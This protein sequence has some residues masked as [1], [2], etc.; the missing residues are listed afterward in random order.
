MGNAGHQNVN[1]PITAQ[2]CPLRFM[3]PTVWNISGYK[4]TYIEAHPSSSLCKLFFFP[5]HFFFKAI[6][7]G[8]S[9]GETISKQLRE[10][11]LGAAMA[12]HQPLSSNL[13]ILVALVPYLAT[14]GLLSRACDIRWRG[15][16]NCLPREELHQTLSS[17]CDLE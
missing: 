13:T 6:W 3:P 5:L 7:R 16:R 15:G 17:L 9:R 12:C 4:Y 14:P 2:R 8:C 10:Q 1:F 11:Q